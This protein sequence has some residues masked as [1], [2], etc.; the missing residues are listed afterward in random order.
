MGVGKKKNKFFGV[1]GSL[2]SVGD[3]IR[4]PRTHYPSTALFLRSRG[5]SRAGFIG[6]VD[7]VSVTPSAIIIRIE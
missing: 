2:F 1:F 3:L 4:S 5:Y 6:R 7:W